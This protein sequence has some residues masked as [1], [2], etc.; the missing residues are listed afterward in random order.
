MEEFVCAGRN[1]AMRRWPLVDF[2]PPPEVH[3]EIRRL[4]AQLERMLTDGFS[5]Q[6][7][8]VVRV[9]QEMDRLVL[10]CYREP[11]RTAPWP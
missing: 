11:S 5:M 10:A 6:D 4:R 8:E 1:L 9:S 3:A 2:T 7:L